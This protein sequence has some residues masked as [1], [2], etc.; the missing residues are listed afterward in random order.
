VNSGLYVLET[1]GQNALACPLQILGTRPLV[2]RYL[3]PC[4]VSAGAYSR[5]LG[6]CGFLD[7]DTVNNNNNIIDAERLN[8]A[9]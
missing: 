7:V 1:W 3:R 2:S 4:F 6:L 9:R 8:L 5:L